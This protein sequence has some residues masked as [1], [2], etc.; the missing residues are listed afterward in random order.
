MAVWFGAIAAI[1]HDALIILGLFAIL[2]TVMPFSME[3][4]RN[5]IAA[6]LTIIGYSINDTVVVFDRIREYITERPKTSL[7]E[8]VNEAVSSTL[9]RTLMTSVTTLLVVLILFFFGGPDLKS[10]SFALIVGIVVG[11]YSSIFVATPLAVDFLKRQ[12]ANK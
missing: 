12:E 11:T 3:M 4:N 9:S 5:I 7:E 1:L 6:L 10:L 2:K 8:N